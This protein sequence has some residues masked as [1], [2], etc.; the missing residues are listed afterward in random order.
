MR[1]LWWWM[2]AHKA[3]V[4]Q[5]TGMLTHSA[6]GSAWMGDAGWWTPEVASTFRKM[7]R[8][9]TRF[10]GPGR[11]IQCVWMERTRRSRTGL[12]PGLTF[13]RY[14]P[15]SGWSEKASRILWEVMMDMS[16]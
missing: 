1:K 7:Q 10:E 5:G 3:L 14:K 9:G 4:D 11:T 8:N 6:C 16:G 2:P 13:R 12:S 15:R